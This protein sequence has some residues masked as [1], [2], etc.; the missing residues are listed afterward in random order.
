L[1]DGGWA[2]KRKLLFLIIVLAISF[3]LLYVTFHNGGA[4]DIKQKKKASPT[5]DVTIEPYRLPLPIMDACAMG[6]V[7][8]PFPYKLK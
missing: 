6:T 2:I 1:S 3:A 4:L 5:P 7:K 8:I